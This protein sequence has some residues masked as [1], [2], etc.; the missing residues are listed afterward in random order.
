FRAIPQLAGTQVRRNTPN[1]LLHIL[2]AQ[3]QSLAAISH[4]PNHHMNMGMLGVVVLCRYPFE[5]CSQILLHPSEQFARKSW[6]IHFVTEFRRHDNFPHLLIARSLPALKLPRDVDGFSLATESHGPG[7][8]L[9]CRALTRNVA[10][11][12]L[13][14]S[15]DLILQVRYADRATLVVRAHRFPFSSWRAVTCLSAAAG[16]VHEQL[17]S[18]RPGCAF[19][20]RDTRLWWPESEFAV[21]V[22]SCH[23]P[24]DPSL[25]RGHRQTS[26]ALRT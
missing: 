24:P 22:S 14:L 17:E 25:R 16:V 9:K 18:V 20:P 7:I 10:P 11:V 8:V 4:T 19:V 15:S 2:T 26:P 23:G 12:C 3:T 1:P 5:I 21:V 6:Q 13:P